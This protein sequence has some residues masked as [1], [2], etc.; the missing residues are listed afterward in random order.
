MDRM[1]RIEPFSS[2]PWTERIPT[3]AEDAEPI[4]TSVE[5]ILIVT[6]ASARN[7]IVGSGGATK[8]V[9]LGGRD[10]VTTSFSAT[11][12]A[13]S[14]LSPYYAE[15]EAV[16]RA[17]SAIPD[18]VA[19]RTITVWTRNH[20]VLSAVT[21]PRQQSGQKVIRKIYDEVRRLK[22]MC[23]KVQMGWL[24]DHVYCELLRQAKSEARA[25]TARDAAP[26]A[27]CEQARESVR[28]SIVAEQR[29][30]KR[31][32]PQGVGFKKGRRSIAWKT[33]RAPSTMI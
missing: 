4:A 30:A 27:P 23:N 29:Q 33:H 1:E 6:S 28:N 17:L 3:L 12:G 25:A 15:L 2:A 18:S 31:V 32:I 5:D 9:L 14:E 11:L 20:S 22:V 21:H 13:R 24:P 19:L 26:D 7:G 10:K 8:G 16:A